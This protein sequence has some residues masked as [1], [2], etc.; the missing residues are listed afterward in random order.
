M[1][2][3]QS[4]S[5]ASLAVTSGAGESEPGGVPPLLE[6]RVWHGSIQTR[7]RTR[8]H[9]FA[10]R[11]SRRSEVFPAP[12]APSPLR[13]LRERQFGGNPIKAPPSADALY[14]NSGRRRQ[15]RTA[16]KGFGLFRCK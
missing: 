4:N 9:R 7:R 13:S 6:I 11:S 1:H 16:I 3:D 8:N 10:V 2:C 14:S 15:F 12:L 5:A